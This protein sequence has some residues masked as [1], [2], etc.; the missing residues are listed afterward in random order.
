MK[1]IL[2]GDPKEI[3]ALVLATQERRC[4]VVNP[5]INLDFESVAKAIH[6]TLQGTA[7]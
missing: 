5:K 6:G 1:L 4:E 2:E 3:A 7:G